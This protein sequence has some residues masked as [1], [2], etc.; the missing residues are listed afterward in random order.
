MN[1]NLTKKDILIWI[2]GFCVLGGLIY[3]FYSSKKTEYQP[4]YD[5]D[6]RIIKNNSDFYT[7]ANC[8]NKLIGYVNKDN[9]E[10]VEAVLTKRYK[11]DNKINKNNAISKLGIEKNSVFKA[12]KILYKYL[13]EHKYKY[14]VYGIIG[15]DSITFDSNFN[16]KN[17]QDI[18]FIVY[19][20]ENDDGNNM[21]SIE[22]YDCLEFNDGGNQLKKVDTI[23]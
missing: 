1:L 13:D 19:A 10:A 2:L 5:K 4:E 12:K 7:I 16:E 20:I 6:A 18:Y 15:E 8:V 3:T 23:K 22:P 11:H 9:N 21:F 14:Y 17:A